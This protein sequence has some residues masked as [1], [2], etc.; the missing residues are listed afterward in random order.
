MYFDEI[1]LSENSK[2]RLGFFMKIEEVQVA[3]FLFLCKQIQAKTLFD[4]GANV[5]FYSLITRKYFPHIKVLSFE[6][7]PETFRELQVN[8]SINPGMSNQCYLFN[9]ALS[10]S[11]GVID[12]VDYGDMSGR[13]GIANTS[14]HGRTTSTKIIQIDTTRLDNLKNEASSCCI[15]KI[16]TEGHEVEVLRGGEEVFCS[17]KCVIQIEDG[18]GKSQSEISNIFDTYGYTKILNVGPDSYY[19]NIST[20]MDP[21]ARLHLFEESVNFMIQHRWNLN[22]T[23]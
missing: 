22:P 19:T 7:T 2:K 6:P 4:I 5:G 1:S 8:I 12:F 18:H 14:I 15:F 21:S 20:L 3:V 17:N 9:S 11:V 13:N 23:I 16:D 10:S